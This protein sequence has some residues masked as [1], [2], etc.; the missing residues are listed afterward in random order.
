MTQN[1]MTPPEHVV[2]QMIEQAFGP[3]GPAGL[4]NSEQ[5]L[6]AF[7]MFAG[8][9]AKWGADQELK[10][11]CEWLDGVG[12]LQQQL[13]ADRRPKPPS[14]K[15]RALKGLAKMIENGHLAPDLAAEIRAVVE[16]APDA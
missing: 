16:M 10:A 1:T 11:C 3:L 5:L 13:R 15:D 7:V 6:K 12:D 14:M 8:A 4:G 9:A 2:A